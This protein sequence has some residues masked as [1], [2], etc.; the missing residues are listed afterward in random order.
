MRWR[1]TL[2][3]VALLFAA[4]PVWA[5]SLPGAPGNVAA[6]IANDTHDVSW[7]AP[8]TGD[9]AF[10]YLVQIDGPG[11]PP[12]GVAIPSGTTSLSL[13]MTGLPFGTYVISVRALNAVGLGP[14]SAAVSVAY[15]ATT[16]PSVPQ[17]LAAS[18]AGGVLTVSWDPPATGTPVTH[19]VLSAAGPSLGAAAGPVTGTSISA[20]IPLSAGQYLFAVS[21]ANTAGQG[22]TTP[23]VTLQ[24]GPA[25]VPSA[26]VNL[27]AV[28]A[29]G[30]LT[31]T[32]LPPTSGRPIDGYRL[33]ASGPGAPGG[34]ITV[35]DTSFSVPA[36]GLPAGL[37]AF[38]VSAVYAVGVGPLTPITTLQIGP[39]AVPSV[40]LNFMAGIANGVLTI[41]WLP[42]VSGGPIDFYRLQASGP[43]SPGGSVQVSGTSMAVPATGLPAGTYLF[44][45][46]AVNVVGEGPAT[47][48]ATLTITPALPSE[49]LHLAASVIAGQLLVS[50]DPPALG[51]VD[52]YVLRATGTSFNGTWTNRLGAQ[53]FMADATQMT[54]GVYNF[55]VSGEN[56]LGEGPPTAPVSVTIGP[57]CIAP[58][59]PVLS[60][61]ASGGAATLSWTTPPGGAVTGYTLQVTVASAGGNVVSA[62]VGALT[63]I[64]GPLTPGTYVFQ[65]A[66]RSACGPGPLSNPVTLTV[67]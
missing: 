10:A 46:S 27:R 45:V 48:V 9:A 32:W 39:A 14:A 44:A 66:A 51:F 29:N 1:S 30:V 52:T 20:A 47:A 16:V 63:V 21:A 17:N 11:L 2:A 65:V 59:A 57:P 43:G 3:V 4:T 26:P 40:P 28:I 60:G 41:S 62:D 38:A 8:T 19:Y 5:Q 67:P 7:A 53:V 24:I 37:Y 34:A 55:T 12:G 49:P 15:G 42:P 56:A 64:S 58:A 36:G 61:S 54:P 33:Y 18:Y 13:P 23:I 50:W 31:V 6:A 25:A 35:T 22:P